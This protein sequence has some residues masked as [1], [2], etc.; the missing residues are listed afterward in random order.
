M[1]DKRGGTNPQGVFVMDSMDE[2]HGIPTSE[3]ST[4]GIA[5]YDANYT[6][7]F[8]SERPRSLPL[9]GTFMDR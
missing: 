4:F 9:G 1:T 7:M 6:H 3:S 5:A 2:D 8:A